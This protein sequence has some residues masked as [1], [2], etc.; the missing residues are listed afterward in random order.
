MKYT[1][2]AAL[3]AACALTLAACGEK[4]QADQTTESAPA[5]TTA[6]APAEPAPAPAPVEPAPATPEAP[7]PSGPS[8]YSYRP[9]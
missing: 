3:L 7:L 2:F 4:K 9:K 6:P 5:E 8:Q 1:F